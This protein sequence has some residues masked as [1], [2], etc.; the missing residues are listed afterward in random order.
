MYEED[1]PIA[2]KITDLANGI[3]N[4]LQGMLNKDFDKDEMETKNYSIGVLIGDISGEY[5]EGEMPPTLKFRMQMDEA[6]IED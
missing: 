6:L 5:L 4:T 3:K 2:S 1:L